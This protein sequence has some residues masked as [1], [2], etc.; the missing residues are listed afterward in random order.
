VGGREY[1]LF[2]SEE[3]V[4][5][6]DGI[7]F[8]HSLKTPRYDEAD[9]GLRVVS[10]AHAKMY[11]FHAGAHVDLFWGSANLSHSA[12]LAGGSRANVDLL[13]HSRLSKAEWQK[14]LFKDLPPGHRWTAVTPTGEP[15]RYDNIREEAGW[16]LLHAIV[17]KG[18][19]TLEASASRRV[20]LRLRTDGS[21]GRVE[22]VLQFGNGETVIPEKTASR[23]GFGLDQAPRSLE[24][25]IGRSRE[26]STIPVNVL[27][28]LAGSSHAMDLAQQLSWEFTG[29]PLPRPGLA[30]PP[31]RPSDEDGEEAISMDEEELTRS[32]HQGELD[33]FVL[34]WR[35]IARR[36]AASFRGNLGL[37][38]FHVEW[39][40]TLVDA[41]ARHSPEAWPQYKRE[42]VR[43]LLD[44]ER[45]WHA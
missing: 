8:C 11:A 36:V 9:E 22:C 7:D 13:I 26:W 19:V 29:R 32:E 16:R 43:E 12:W 44:L 23:L 42:L 30:N 38:R 4:P 18:R 10:K 45:E 27:E 39:I 3:R 37:R 25:A 17:E 33:R 35:S 5:R 1:H 28:P 6:V 34:E 31:Q 21:R 20:R 41:E 40:L 15:L 2:S 24:W 14:F